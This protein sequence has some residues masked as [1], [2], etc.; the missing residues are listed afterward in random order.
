MKLF[1][2]Q[3]R[4]LPL[5]WMAEAAFVPVR[6]ARLLRPRLAISRLVEGATSHLVPSLLDLIW[7]CVEVQVC[8]TYARWWKPRSCAVIPYWRG[9][10]G[11]ATRCAELAVRIVAGGIHTASC[12]SIWERVR[13]RGKCGSHAFDEA[14]A[15]P[16]RMSFPSQELGTSAPDVSEERRGDGPLRPSTSRSLL[17][18]TDFLGLPMSI[19]THDARN[20]TTRKH[21]TCASLD[22]A[23]RRRA[24]L[25]LGAF[26]CVACRRGR[27][28]LLARLL[29]ATTFNPQSERIG[30]DPLGTPTDTL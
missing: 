2:R 29:S 1:L 18:P 4:T 23:G 20:G 28:C 5:V 24:S 8:G 15:R 12:E 11:E 6:T 16:R 14:V 19:P 30:D 25:P 27:F 13:G 7:A 9:H 21:A 17:A 3:S 22:V 26:R 10:I